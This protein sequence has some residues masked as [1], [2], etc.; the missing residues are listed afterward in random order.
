MFVWSLKNSKHGSVMKIQ[1]AHI[2]VDLW[3][4]NFGLSTLLLKRKMCATFML[5]E[6]TQWTLYLP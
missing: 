5:L 3:K 4:L 1:Q 6:K 2:T